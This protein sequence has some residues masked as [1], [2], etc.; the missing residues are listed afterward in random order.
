[1]AEILISG[2]DWVWMDAASAQH[3]QISE[4]QS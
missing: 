1:M 4:G 3:I 2:H